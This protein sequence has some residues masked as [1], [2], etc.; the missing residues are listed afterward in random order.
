MSGQDAPF[1]VR[2]VRVRILAL[3]HMG[4]V[5]WVQRPEAWGLQIEFSMVWLGPLALEQ[6]G[7]KIWLTQH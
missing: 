3:L 4:S 1:G 7:F 6:T 2:Q 5:A